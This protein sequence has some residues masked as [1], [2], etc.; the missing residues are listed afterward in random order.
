MSVERP[1]EWPLDHEEVENWLSRQPFQ[2]A[3]T[4]KHNPHS[5]IVKYKVKDKRMFELVVLHIRE[6][7]YQQKWVG[8]VVHAV[9][10]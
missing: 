6:H 9:R 5:Y 3:V 8:T 2:E 7:G 10:G 4:S 1:G